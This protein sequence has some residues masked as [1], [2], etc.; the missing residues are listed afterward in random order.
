MSVTQT[1]GLLIAILVMTPIGATVNASLETLDHA[2]VTVRFETPLTAAAHDLTGDM[3]RVKAELRDLFGWRLLQRPTVVLIQNRETFRKLAGH[4][5]IAAYAVPSDNLI[6]IEIGSL[7]RHAQRGYNLLK[8]E[9]AHLYLHAHSAPNRIPRWL[10]EGIAQ[11]V[12]DGVADLLQ[13]PRPALVTEAVLSGSILPLARLEDDFPIDDNALLLA[14]AQS[15]SVVTF[16]AET[17][18]SDKIFKILVQLNEGDRLEDSVRRNLSISLQELEK[19]WLSAQKKPAVFLAALA[20]YIY[21]ILFLAA[22]L[23]TVVGFIRFRIKK[24]RYRDE[25]DD[26]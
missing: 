22:A 4:R 18:G 3:L 14:Y 8:H 7:K 11:W 6:V 19:Q 26:L 21:E 25:D 16:I 15:R 24:H 1:M 5:L 2:E 10:D 9:M 20:G 23:L 12:S 17:Y 13:E